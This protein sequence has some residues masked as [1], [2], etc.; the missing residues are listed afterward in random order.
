[1]DHTRQRQ[2]LPPAAIITESSSIEIQAL[3]DQVNRKSEVR[4]RAQQRHRIRFRKTEP[5]A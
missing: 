5:D 2:Y 4:N 1:M 3:N